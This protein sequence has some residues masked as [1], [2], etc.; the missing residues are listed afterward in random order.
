MSDGSAVAPND[1]EAL[2]K[3]ADAMGVLI[4]AGV[5]PE[6]AAEQVGLSGLTFWEGRPVTLEYNAE[7]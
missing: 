2:K 4:R 7:V 1:P 3:K 5:K 6:S